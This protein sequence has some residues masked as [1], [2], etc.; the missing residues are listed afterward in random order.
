MPDELPAPSPEIIREIQ[1]AEQNVWSE[2]RNKRR[3]QFLIRHSL[4]PM[5]C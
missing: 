4:R 3:P 5:L 2:R 1:A